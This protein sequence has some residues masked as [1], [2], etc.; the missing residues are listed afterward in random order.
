MP[1]PPQTDAGRSASRSSKYYFE[2]V[3]LEVEGTL[4]RVLKQWATSWFSKLPPTSEKEG[5]GDGATD[6]NPIRLSG[7][8]KSEFEVLLELMI[9]SEKS[10]VPTFSKEEWIGILKLGRLW[11]MP[12]AASLAIEKL[13]TLTKSPIEKIQLGRTFSVSSWL[14]DGYTKLI[15]DHEDDI[16][17]E[18]YRVLGLEAMNRILLAK[19]KLKKKA[20]TASANRTEF[21]CE[22]CISGKRGWSKVAENATNCTQCGGSL[23]SGGTVIYVYRP[24]TSWKSC[25]ALFDSESALVN[26]TDKEVAEL[27]GEEIREAER[28]SVCNG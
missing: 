3:V 6:E 27:F 19:I 23:S 4:Y 14:K 25:T 13:S 17:F 18:E 8:T 2:V 11:N 7:C 1:G 10:G 5:N 20:E 12:K 9:Q 28:K 24:H 16:T 21:Y 22:R 26:G 15:G